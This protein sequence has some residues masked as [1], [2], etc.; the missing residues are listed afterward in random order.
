[1]TGRGY[2]AVCHTILDEIGD[3]M[4]FA[5]VSEEVYAEVNWSI[6]RGEYLA[7]IVDRRDEME[8]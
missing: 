7:S 8:P 1:M 2:T 6:D 4:D 3:R 5:P